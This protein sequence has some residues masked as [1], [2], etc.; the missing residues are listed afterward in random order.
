MT[1]RT[2][3]AAIL[4]IPGICCFLS[5]YAQEQRLLKLF[6]GISAVTKKYAPEK[7]YVQ[8]DRPS[9]SAGDTLWFKTYL[10]NA[11]FLH[12]SPQSGLLYLEIADKNNEVIKLRWCRYITG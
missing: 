10:F 12:A 5:A 8:T 3:I 6:N 1:K 7:L 9:Y 11:A 4:F 2:V